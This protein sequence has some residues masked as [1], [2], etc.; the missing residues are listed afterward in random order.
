[1]FQVTFQPN[2]KILYGQIALE[3]FLSTSL[4]KNTYSIQNTDTITAAV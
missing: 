4:T 3:A 1:M 2:R